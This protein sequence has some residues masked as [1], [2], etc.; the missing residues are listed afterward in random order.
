MCDVEQGQTTGAVSVKMV[1]KITVKTVKS[2]LFRNSHPTVYSIL[3][4]SK[5]DGGHFGVN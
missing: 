1:E 3:R 2:V 4:G 5:I